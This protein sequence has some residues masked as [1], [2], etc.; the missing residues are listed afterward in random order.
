MVNTENSEGHENFSYWNKL[1]ENAPEAYKKW[2]G[3]EEQYLMKH[4]RP[5]SKILEVGCGEGRSLAYLA[6]NGRVVYG[7]DHDKR[8][9]LLARKKLESVGLN[10]NIMTME[11]SDLIFKDNVFDYVMSLS[12]PANFG[13]QKNKI[14]SEMRRVVKPDGEIIVNVFN[15]DAFDERIK[16]YRSLGPP[17]KEIVG[18]TVIFEDPNKEF[19]SEQFSREQLEEIARASRLTPIEISKQGI[20]YLC[21]FRK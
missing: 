20:G 1:L 9:G 15:E 18:T 3:F 6:G 17:I 21:R 10:A 2:F 14:Y 16:F 8:A 13:N 5:E 4:I 12:T 7:I 19:I 11:A